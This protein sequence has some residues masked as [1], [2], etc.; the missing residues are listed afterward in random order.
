MGAVRSRAVFP[1]LWKKQV[2]GG[3]CGYRELENWVWSYLATGDIVNASHHTVVSKASPY[4]EDRE[5]IV[6][7]A[8]ELAARA[9]AERRW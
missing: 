1:I 5:E 9:G 6:H 7:T 8:R 2:Q 4:P 3:V